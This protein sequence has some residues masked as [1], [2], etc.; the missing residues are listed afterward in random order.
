MRLQNIVQKYILGKDIGEYYNSEMEFY[1]SPFDRAKQERLKKEKRKMKALCCWIPNISYLSNVISLT[2]GNPWYS[3]INIGGESLR[4][5]SRYFFNLIEADKELFREHLLFINNSNC[6]ENR[7]GEM[8]SSSGLIDS[9][10]DFE[11]PSLYD[12][13]PVNKKP[14]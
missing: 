2:T 1:K 4:W 3:L 13:K 9:E 5:A 6:E 8:G 12:L 10:G 7:M 14:I 11:D